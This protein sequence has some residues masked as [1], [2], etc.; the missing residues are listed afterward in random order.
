[1]EYYLKHHKKLDDTKL[2]I[3][4][5]W[6]VLPATDAVN[7]GIC[8]LFYNENNFFQLSEIR[9]IFLKLNSL[10]LEH[11]NNTKNDKNKGNYDY[12]QDYWRIFE[13]SMTQI[14]YVVKE[15]DEGTLNIY[16]CGENR[17]NS[18]VYD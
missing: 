14:E 17:K 3:V 12:S 18:R 9:N 15:M 13:E 8:N 6:L 1:M 16:H 7:E 10:Y 2:F 5:S 11:F 4:S